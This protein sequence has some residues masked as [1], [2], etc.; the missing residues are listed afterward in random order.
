MHRHVVFAMFSWSVCALVC[1]AI[2]G[3][4][5]EA[6]VE[7]DELPTAAPPPVAAPPAAPVTVPDPEPVEEPPPAPADAAA[8][9]PYG[10]TPHA[11][12]GLIEAEHYDEGAPGIAYS[13]VDEENQGVD[14]RPDTQVD[15]EG[16]PDASNGHG[17]GWTRA[18]EWLNYTVQVAQTGTYTVD[19]PVASNG[20]GG[21]FHLE[22]DGT[23]VSGPIEV[24]DTG[25]WDQLATIRAE[26]I[27]LA[28]GTHVLR[29]VMDTIGESGAT[30]DI[31]YMR[32]SLAEPAP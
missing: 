1:A 31:D 32:F 18:G 3:C 17:I 14:Y 15:I 4:G 9:T 24:P 28:E 23:D 13:D 6:P 5:G 11:I 22:I 12:P 10:G 2:I 8:S 27:E 26:G 19:F 29:M 7:P 25:G 30:G 16:R 21:V 20:P